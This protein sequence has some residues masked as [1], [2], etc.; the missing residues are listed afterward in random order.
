MLVETFCNWFD[1]KESI[2]NSVQPPRIVVIAGS[3]GIYG[4]NTKRIFEK[5]GIPSVNLSSSVCIELNYI[6]YHARKYLKKGDIVVVAPE[7][8][9]YGSPVMSTTNT[10]FILKHDRKYFFQLPL[11]E[12]LRWLYGENLPLIFGG[13]VQSKDRTASIAFLAR[14]N[15]REHLNEHGDYT[16]HGKSTQSVE[17]AQGLKVSHAAT[18]IKYLSR[19]KKSHSGWDTIRDFVGWCRENGI[20]VFATFPSMAHYPEYD[21]PEAV[22]G[23]KDIVE[24]YHAMNVSTLGI[25]EDF[26]WDVSEFY[27][28]HYHLTEE[29][30]LKR[31]DKILSLLE[32]H[33]KRR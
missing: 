2:I 33:L 1:R 23:F 15:A 3:N 8:Q 25:P 18:I 11:G 28:S 21:A 9:F 22:D 17:A 20:V 26:I 13:L 30:M 12:K 7:Y 4:I 27:D 19:N 31:T 24:K 14:Q 16:G 29:A 10:A 6:F 32:P 5:T